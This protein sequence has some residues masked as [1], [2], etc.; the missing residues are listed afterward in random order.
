[1]E[2]SFD[3]VR[4]YVQNGIV[5]VCSYNSLSLSQD[6]LRFS[7]SSTGSQ[8]STG[9]RFDSSVELYPSH[10]RYRLGGGDSLQRSLGDFT[11]THMTRGEFSPQINRRSRE[12]SHDDS[13]P[14]VMSNHKR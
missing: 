1:M 12:R 10:Q 6:D 3:L 14:R 13:P 8:G 4:V 7:R 11:D 2:S 5:D 9:G